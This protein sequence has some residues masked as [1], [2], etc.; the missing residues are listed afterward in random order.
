MYFKLKFSMWFY[1]LA[2][3]KKERNFRNLGFQEGFCLAVALL[4]LKD[5]FKDQALAGR[6]APN[7]L[8]VT[9]VRLQD[10]LL[11]IIGRKRISLNHQNVSH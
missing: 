5:V 2:L 6:S 11:N 4:P 9:E 7:F 8:S 3:K 10:S 1:T